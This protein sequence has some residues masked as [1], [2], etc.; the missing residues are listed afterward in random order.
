MKS[1][2]RRI[3]AQR[4]Q[5]ET[6]SPIESEPVFV[7]VGKLRRPHGVKGESLVGVLTDFPERLQP[8]TQLFLGEEHRPLTIRNRR[9]HHKDML[10]IFEEFES[11]EM[12]EHVRNAPLFV[13]IADRPELEEG[14]YYHH[15]L[16]GLKVI[17]ENGDNLGR[18]GEILETGANDVYVVQTNDGQ[19]LL[20]PA[21]ADVI[22]GVDLEK[23]QI[24]VRLIPGLRPD[25]SGG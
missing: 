20:L 18:L 24:T 5:Q 4:R 11:R 15:Q 14:D 25:V 13:R 8:G 9:E 6:G 12:L 22:L 10:I 23:Q 2:R 19:D 7:L 1:N 17:E 3:A 21:I 16:V